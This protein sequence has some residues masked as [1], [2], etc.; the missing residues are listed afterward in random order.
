MSERNVLD[1]EI[2]RRQSALFCDLL[3]AINRRAGGDHAYVEVIDSTNIV[4]VS[5]YTVDGVTHNI[6]QRVSLDYGSR[7]RV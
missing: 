2:E 4:I 1:E 6:S 7:P 3:G 5:R